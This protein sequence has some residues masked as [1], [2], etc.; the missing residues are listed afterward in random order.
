MKVAFE[1]APTDE[2]FLEEM[3]KLALDGS[4]DSTLGSCHQRLVLSL[5]EKCATLTQ[6]EIGKVA[7]NLLNCQNSIESESS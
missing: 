1:L 7:V 2:K 3:K 5:K 6:E 4:S